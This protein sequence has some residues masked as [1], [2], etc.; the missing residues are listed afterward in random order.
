M[1]KDQTKRIKPSVLQEDKDSVAAIATLAPAYTPANAAFA[2]ATLQTALTTM[3]TAQNTEVQKQAD[4]D[5][6]R[7]DA[8]AKEWA[9][10]NAVLEARKQVIAQYGS[11]SEQVQSVGLKRKSEYK[12]PVRKPKPAPAK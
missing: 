2:L 1:A 3:T 4:A 9:F 7:D 10:H 8:C 5:A 11:D 12:K 6:A